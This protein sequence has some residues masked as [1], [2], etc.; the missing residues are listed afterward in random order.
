MTYNLPESVM[1]DTDSEA[2]TD[3][4]RSWILLTIGTTLSTSS[5]GYIWFGV[6]GIT[7]AGLGFIALSFVAAS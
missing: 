4:D 7:L 2:L 3:S 5:L 1:L 6:A